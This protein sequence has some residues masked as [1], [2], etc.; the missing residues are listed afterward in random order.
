M[1]FGAGGVMQKI[2]DATTRT[3]EAT[4]EMADNMDGSEVEF[5]D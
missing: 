4:E 3:A 5:G 1:L 2:A